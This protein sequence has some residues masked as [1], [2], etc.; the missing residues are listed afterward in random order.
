[1]DAFYAAIE[2]RDRPEL[3]GR[4]VIVGADPKSGRGRGV[5]SAAS[6]EA[7]RFGVSSAMPI[8]RA[9]RLCPDGAFVPVDMD[10]YARVSDQLMEILRRYTDLVEPLSI[11]EA[12]LDVTGSQ[13]AFGNGEAIARTIKD[14]VRRDLALSA[15][16]G[17]AST[18]LA[19]KIASDLR[20]PDG[21]VIVPPGGEAAFLAP[22]PLRK[23][24]GIGP[25]TEQGL[26]RAGLHTVGDLA[27]ADPDKLERRL[28]THG[29]DLIR[30]A[31]GLDD[32]P[33]T[34]DAGL[35]KSLGQE[36]TFDTDISDLTRLRLTLLALAD[37]VARRLREHG[38]AGRTVTLKFRDAGFNTLTRAATLTRP[39]DRSE[40]L[41]Q[42]AWDLF[43]QVHVGQRVRLLGISVSGFGAETQLALF[44]TPQASRLDRAQDAL[45]GRFGNGAVT[46][47]SLLGELGPKRR[48]RRD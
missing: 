40:D 39:T 6:Y 11:D 41:F 36:H 32:R 27:A 33:V 30:L 37:N 13:R 2:Q 34:A 10:K 7:R 22:L 35:A 48:P 4:P 28:G 43:R 8:S 16:V 17:V 31:R 19:A 9:Y 38:M 44:A 20:K 12:F 47:A 25:K 14:A 5:V 3:R 46:R 18:K 26:V 42:T 15:S 24:W 23:L 29:H 45:L 21:L 1:M